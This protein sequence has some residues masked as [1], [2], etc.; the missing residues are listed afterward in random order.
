MNRLKKSYNQAAWKPQNSRASRPAQRRRPSMS[1]E[2]E[3]EMII[4]AR[5]LV[6]GEVV[7]PR[8]EHP[9]PQVT[10]PR[11]GPWIPQSCLTCEKTT[12]I[13]SGEIQRTYHQIRPRR[14][15]N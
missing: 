1:P 5:P 11:P 10:P 12:L 3:D 13:P 14:G 15:A 6:N 2:E 9:V 8:V 7:K 4:V